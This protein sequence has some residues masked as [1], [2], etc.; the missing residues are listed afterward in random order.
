MTKSRAKGKRGARATA[1]SPQTTVE[2]PPI[3]MRTGAAIRHSRLERALTLRDVAAAAKLSVAMLSRIENGQSSAS[4]SVLERIAGALGIDLS[5]LFAEIED[6]QGTAQLIKAAD[7]MEVVRTGTKHGHTYHLLSYHRGP[8]KAFEPFLIH[9]DKKSERYPRFQHPGME[10]IYMLKG[11]MEYRFGDRTFL[12][13][14]GDSFTFSGNVL[15]GP[16]KLLD[17]QIEF[18]AVIV[19]AE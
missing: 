4:L 8:R 16:D 13:E 2:K 7:R 3:D 18:I 6:A 10:F 11:R 17:D 15:H 12:I 5:T 1:P 14:P 19:Y 9:M